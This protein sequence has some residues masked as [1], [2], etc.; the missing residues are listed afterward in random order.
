KTAM[1]LFSTAGFNS[2]GPCRMD[3]LQAFHPPLLFSG[4]N[5]P[6]NG[7][8]MELASFGT[9]SPPRTLTPI[10]QPLKDYSQNRLLLLY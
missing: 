10:T 9:F 8:Q 4:E 3:G 5:P 6:F 1:K 2:I 7:P